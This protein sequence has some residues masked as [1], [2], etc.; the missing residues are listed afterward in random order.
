MSKWEVH[1]KLNID[2]ICSLGT[3]LTNSQPCRNIIVCSLIKK[4]MIISQFHLVEV[5]D[6]AHH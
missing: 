3:I 4:R 1:F 2:E 6:K 5:H